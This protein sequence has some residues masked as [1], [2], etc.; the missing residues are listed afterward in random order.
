[1][2]TG[3]NA[4]TGMAVARNVNML[5][6]K[7]NSDM[8]V[9]MGEAAAPDFRCVNFTTV[10]AGLSVDYA[11]VF[12]SDPS[13]T[14]LVLTATAFNALCQPSSM[15]TGSPL[16][17]C[18]RECDIDTSCDERMSLIPPKDHVNSDAPI[19]SLMPMVRVLA[20]MK[21]NDKVQTINLLQ[22]RGLVVGMVG[23][24]G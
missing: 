14:E 3:D 20:R 6:R 16:S 19:V 17:D 9:I 1:M 7:E 4:H 12:A 13:K 22:D 24:G 2:C 10:D 15:V 18:G 23:D 21:P 5:A 8:T 11:D